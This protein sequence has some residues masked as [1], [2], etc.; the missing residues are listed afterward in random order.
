MQ[1]TSEPTCLKPYFNANPLPQVWMCSL[2]TAVTLP[3]KPLPT[4]M[5]RA[6]VANWE[7]LVLVNLTGT[8][9]EAWAVQAP[10]T[11]QAP[12][13]CSPSIRQQVP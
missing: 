8:R 2:V 12:L 4:A 9:A 13:L 1:Q 7:F 6:M 11:V 3:S 10:Q 5:M